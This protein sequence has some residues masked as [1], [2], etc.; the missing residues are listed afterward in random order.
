MKIGACKRIEL[1]MG[2]A[3]TAPFSRP[4]QE[5][6]LSWRASAFVKSLTRHPD[7]TRLTAREKLILFVLADCHNDDKDFAW[8]GLDSASDQSLTSRSRFCQLI[9]RMEE[10]GTLEIERRQ[11]KSN[12]YRFAGL[13]RSS[14]P[15][16]RLS[17][18]T[19]SIAMRPHPSD[20]C[21]TRTS[22]EPL[23]TD[24]AVRPPL[25]M[26]QIEEAIRESQRQ[27]RPADDILKEMRDARNKNPM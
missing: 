27:H 12:L 17:D 6:M 20:S 3:C 8:P 14:D 2:A 18:P 13:V 7:G 19:R 4:L 23:V 1:G 22:I 25:S 21:D 10:K 9:K 16:V 26:Y 5:G 24:I 11:G 15:P